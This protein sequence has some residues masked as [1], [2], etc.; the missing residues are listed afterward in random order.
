MI[1]HH[2]F[3][4]LSSGRENWHTANMYVDEKLLRFHTGVIYAGTL[5]MWIFLMALVVRNEQ[6]TISALL[7]QSLLQLHVGAFHQPD[8]HPI[9]HLC[10]VILTRC[11]PRTWS[12][13]IFSHPSVWLC[14]KC[15]YF[16]RCSS[17]HRC[18]HSLEEFLMPQGSFFS[19]FVGGVNIR[20]LPNQKT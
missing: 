14:L 1:L 15:F 2:C 13:C 7:L 10:T 12:T 20:V 3:T 17:L 16:T 8:F 19:R 5:R 9:I 4:F 18:L 11:F 6:E